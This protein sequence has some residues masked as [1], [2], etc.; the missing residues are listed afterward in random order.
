MLIPVIELA[1][2]HRYRQ[3]SRP[4]L[5]TVW[6][7]LRSVMSSVICITWGTKYRQWWAQP[8]FIQTVVGSV[9]VTGICVCVCR[10]YDDSLKLLQKATAL[11]AR[12]VDYHDKVTSLKKRK[13]LHHMWWLLGNIWLTYCHATCSQNEPVQKRVHKSLKVWSMYAD[14]EESFGTFKVRYLAL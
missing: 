5:L 4:K 10:N 14:L 8:C 11:P 13:Y 3:C 7:Q 6:P 1:S 9:E 12:K 2:A